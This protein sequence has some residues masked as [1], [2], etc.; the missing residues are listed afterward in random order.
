MRRCSNSSKNASK[1]WIKI[2]IKLFILSVNQQYEISKLILLKSY[3]IVPFS[4][5]LNIVSFKIK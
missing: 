3:I 1:A 2:L 5:E 4:V